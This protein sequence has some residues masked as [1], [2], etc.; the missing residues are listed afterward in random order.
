MKKSKVTRKVANLTKGEKH[1]MVRSHE[2]GS[3]VYELS[4]V[5]G[6]SPQSV[7]AYVANAHR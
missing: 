1:Q 6:V 4:K 5:Y 3:T 2:D 7:A